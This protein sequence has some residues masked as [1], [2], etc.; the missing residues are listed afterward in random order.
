MLLDDGSAGAAPAAAEAAQPATGHRSPFRMEPGRLV[1]LDQGRFPFEVVEI[2]CATGAEVARA[3]RELAVRGGPAIAQVAAYGLAL[4]ADRARSAK[5]YVR[6]ATIRG[7]ANAL[8]HA[9]IAPA[10]PRAAVDR[11]MARMSTVGELVDTG[12]EIADAMRA[13]ADA[14]AFETTLDNARLVDAG[15]AALE[16]LVRA[17]EATAASSASASAAEG[18]PTAA[19]RALGV[20]TLGSSGAL[21]GGQV[22]TALAVLA[23]FAG[24]GR[25]THVFVL[26]TR[27]SLDGARLAA[28]ELA[29]AAVPFSI[30][31][32]GAAGWILAS[33]EVDVV[34]VAADRVAR[35][36][37]FLAPIGTLGVAVAA[38]SAGVPVWVCATG[39]A[40]DPGADGVDDLPEE[41]RTANDL[42]RIRGLDVAAPGSTA[43]NPIVDATPGELVSLFVTDAGVFEPPFARDLAALA[44]AFAT[45]SPVPA[46][47]VRG[48]GMAGATSTAR[49]EGPRSGDAPAGDAPAGGALEDPG[50]AE[51]TA[52]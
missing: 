44:V 20:L 6:L 24:S 49:P 52:Q 11:L 37:S 7:T 9:R 2:E 12:D 47:P 26:E 16:D 25:P 51:G 36:G 19:E 33:G 31:V 23:S 39:S 28:W 48:G 43:R 38:A 18:A 30:L 4:T 10:A 3:I 21:A 8:A 34:I 13:E 35:D 22:G 50:S 15:R 17:A 5:P 14:I 41:T 32:D 27:P 40:L 45:R 42:L 46:D 1:V 29:Q